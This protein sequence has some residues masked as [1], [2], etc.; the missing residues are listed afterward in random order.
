MVF[1]VD[2]EAKE[3]RKV[4]IRFD[5]GNQFD[6][7]GEWLRGNLHTHTSPASGCGKIPV[8]G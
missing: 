5:V 8:E 3:G 1:E 4:H 7:E 6:C 2:G